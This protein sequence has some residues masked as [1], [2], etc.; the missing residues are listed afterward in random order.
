MDRVG[1]FTPTPDPFPPQHAL[2][3]RGGVEQVDDRFWFVAP[4]AL[5]QQG[6]AE[7]SCFSSRSMSGAP[8]DSL[9]HMDGDEHRRVRRLIG[10]GFA[11]RAMHGTQGTVRAIA[12]EL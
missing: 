9:L 3:E 5:V 11:P 1:L 7:A 12:E 8:S 4:H 10:R 6:F 2:R